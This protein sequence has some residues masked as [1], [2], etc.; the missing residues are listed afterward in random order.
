M[1]LDVEP[2]T[3]SLCL[4]RLAAETNRA[5]QKDV[6]I[7]T[8]PKS[9]TARGATRKKTAVYNRSNEPGGTQEEH[10]LLPYRSLALPV[11]APPHVK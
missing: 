1:V 7:A 6:T 9:R 11:G 10:R 4:Q 3:G 8:K 2:S 5:S